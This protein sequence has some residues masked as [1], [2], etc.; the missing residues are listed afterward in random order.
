VIASFEIRVSRYAREGRRLNLV[1]SYRD[2]LAIRERLATS[3][4]SHASWQNNLQYSTDRV[5]SLAYRFVLARN[6]ARAFEAAD[7]AISVT[8]ERIWLYA[9]R[10]HAIMLLSRVDEARA[11][12]LHYRGQKNVLNG[13][14]W[15]TV[16]LEDFAEM[17]KAGFTH[18]LRSRNGSRRGDELRKVPARLQNY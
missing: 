17:R 10:A 14:P 6:F 12:Y 7:L 5:G 3:D 18:P 1:H 4:R 8:P 13:K 9:N 11:L 15:E 2:S 16:V